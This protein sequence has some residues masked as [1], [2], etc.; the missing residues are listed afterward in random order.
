MTATT[1]Y[2]RYRIN[3]VIDTAKPVMQN[4]ENIANSA[5]AWITYD[6]SDGKWS[7]IINKAETSVHSFND[8]NIIGAVDLSGTGLDGLYNSVEVQFPNRDLDDNNDFI[9]I[10]LPAIDRKPNEPDNLLKLNYPLIN[11]PVSAEVIGLLELKQSRVDLIVT[12][13]TDFSKN[14]VLAGD[15]I[16]ITNTT[17]GWTNKLFR[18]M[19]VEETDDNDG[20]IKIKITALEYDANVYDTSDINRFTR[21]NADGVITAGAIGTMATPTITKV[22]QDRKPYILVESTVPASDPGLIN[23]VEVWYYP[24]P[25]AELP[26][27]ETVDDDARTYQLHSTITSL[28]TTGFFQ[29]NEEID[30][31]I[32]DFNED[33]FLVKLRAVNGTTQGPF[34]TRSGLIDYQP[35]QT[36]DN[37]TDSTEV[38]LGAGN[39]L[40]TFGLSTLLSLI[41]G[42]MRDGDSGV[43]TFFRKIFSVLEDVTGVDI[44]DPTKGGPIIVA[45]SISYDGKYLLVTTKDGAGNI[46][47][48]LIPV[49]LTTSTEIL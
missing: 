13:D 8:S 35:K 27:W 46:N 24:I 15:V 40:T 48:E 2:T 6:I 17:Y 25:A 5:G 33:N 26:T 37:I 19:Q 11:D 21:S 32:S 36:T 31:Y 1:T 49:N 3:G 29:P 45:T 7:V 47:V 22:Q 18:V 34:S 14:D 30:Y 39:I 16:D 23:G 28:S 44:L 9:R 20:N 42:L 4:L 12:F 43:G 38:D 10:D 41:N